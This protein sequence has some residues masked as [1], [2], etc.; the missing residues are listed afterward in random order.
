V[1]TN[2]LSIAIRPYQGTSSLRGNAYFEISTGCSE[3][4][5]TINCLFSAD[6]LRDLAREFD[7]AADLCDE[8]YAIA[9]AAKIQERQPEAGLDAI[10]SGHPIDMIDIPEFL[11]RHEVTA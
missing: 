4:R 8:N 6:Q 11:H 9:R 2:G 10:I 1:E 7:C 3:G 5:A